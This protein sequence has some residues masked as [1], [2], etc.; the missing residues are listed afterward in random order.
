VYAVSV[1]TAHPVFENHRVNSFVH[2]L[3]TLAGMD[4]SSIEKKSIYRMLG[5]AMFE[6]HSSYSACGLGCSATDELVQAVCDAGPAKGVFG[7]K[8][9]GGGSGGTVCVLCIG[10]EG[11]E[12]VR[13]IAGLFAEKHAIAPV[14][15]TGSSP[16]TRW[17]DVAIWPG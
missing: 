15:F 14:L 13:E 7:A 1:C 2:L 12:T 10:D 17:Q 9:T 11:L 8:I 4:D 5:E 16:G 3:Q 6:S